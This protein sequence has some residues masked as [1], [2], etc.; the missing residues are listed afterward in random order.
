MIEDKPAYFDVVT[1]PSAD[2]RPA[3]WEFDELGAAAVETHG[4]LIDETAAK[5]GVDADVLK[6]V[7]WV[8]NARGHKLGANWLADVLGFSRSKM[9]MNVRS[10][11]WGALA[12]P[13]GDAALREPASNIAAAARLLGALQ[14][15]IPE[16]DQSRVGT[17][18]NSLGENEVNDVG[19]A[20]GRVY[21]Q[22]PWRKT[23]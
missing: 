2:E 4:A 7:M 21:R 1:S 11:F 16:S 17:L 14:Q 22:K 13:D 18:W 8:E 19:A 3:L 20:I 5:Y 10:D 15:R 12:P 9:P 6:A 23:K